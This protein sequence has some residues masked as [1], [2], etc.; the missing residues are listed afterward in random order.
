VRFI[1]VDYGLR[2]GR[3][4]LGTIPNQEIKRIFSTEG[5]DLRFKR[6]AS[7]ITRQRF[8][9]LWE[10]ALES[11]GRTFATIAE[12]RLAVAA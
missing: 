4:G 7:A 9:V 2:D 11:D 8:R 3:A 5:P 1:G 12:E 10:A 6:L